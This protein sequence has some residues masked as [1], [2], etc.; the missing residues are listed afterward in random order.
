MQFCIAE[1][2][3]VGETIVTNSD[4]ILVTNIFSLE[5]L[6]PECIDIRGDKLFIDVMDS[7]NFVLCSPN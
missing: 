3:Y 1:Y 5:N 6:S 7:Q 4:N 2:S